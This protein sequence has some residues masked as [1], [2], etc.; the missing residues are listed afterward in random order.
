MAQLKTEVF[1]FKEKHL[2]NS[3]NSKKTAILNE[4]DAIKVTVFQVIQVFMIK[5]MF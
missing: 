4:N 2:D 1:Q 5:C 3:L